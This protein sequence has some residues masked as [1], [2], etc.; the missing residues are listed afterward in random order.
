MNSKIVTQ[1]IVEIAQSR[2]VIFPQRE[3]GKNGF[4]V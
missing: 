2:S 3:G 1:D 4:E